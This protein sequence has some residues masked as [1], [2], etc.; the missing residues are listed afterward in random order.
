MAIK[1]RHFLKADVARRIE[2]ALRAYDV[3]KPLKGALELL[4]TAEQTLILLN[5]VPVALCV[6]HTPFFTVRGAIELEPQRHLVTVDTGAV[7]F[8][9]NGADVMSPGIVDA[10]EDIGPHDFVVVI[11]ERHK[12]PL[13]VGV[14]LITGSEMIQHAKGKAVHILHHVGDRI[15]HAS[16]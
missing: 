3:K 14:A 1:R 15:W 16:Q 12:K 6:D 11:D 8:I 2:A 13:G 9:R 5:G 7:Q 10:D 4:E